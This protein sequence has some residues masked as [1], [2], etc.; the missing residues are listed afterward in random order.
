M[1]AF[2]AAINAIFRDPNMA[3]DAEYRS[4]G[5]DPATSVR[6]MRTV[7]DVMSEF[8]TGR[9]VAESVA[10][11]VRISEVE[12]LEKGDTF[13]IGGEVFAVIGA[14]RRDSEGLIWKSE[15]RKNEV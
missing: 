1:S 5:A 8:N 4:G 3:V 7:P 12:T 6:V 15:A 10:L 11:D 9:Y 2:S 13:T 14:P